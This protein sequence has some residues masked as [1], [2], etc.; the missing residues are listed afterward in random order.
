[1]H[2][3]CQSSDRSMLRKSFGRAWVFFRKTFLNIYLQNYTKIF[4]GIILNIREYLSL[5]QLGKYSPN[6]L[7]NTLQYQKYVLF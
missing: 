2:D 7:Y 6:P 5:L 4:I 1:M 3:R